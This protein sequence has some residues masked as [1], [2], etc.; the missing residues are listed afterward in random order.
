MP[1]EIYFPNFGIKFWHYIF[2]IVECFLNKLMFDSVDAKVW[3]KTAKSYE[4]KLYLVNFNTVTVT[5]LPREH[6]KR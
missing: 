2:A 6:C 3:G 1:Y 4:S 5:S